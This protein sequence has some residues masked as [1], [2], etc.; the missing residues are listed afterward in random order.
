MEHQVGQG[1]NHGYIE[2]G[3]GQGQYNLFLPGFSYGHYMGDLLF[4]LTLL[5]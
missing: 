5:V 3:E 2:Y 1:R 4:C